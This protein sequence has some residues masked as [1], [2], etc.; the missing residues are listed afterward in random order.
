MQWARI[1]GPGPVAS[2]LASLWA[3]LTG[4][5]GGTPGMPPALTPALQTTPYSG[6]RPTRAKVSQNARTESS[7]ARSSSMAVMCGLPV[8]VRSASAAASPRAGFRQASTT[9]W[10]GSS[11]AMF[12]GEPTPD[13]IAR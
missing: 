8:S 10:P 13:A 3:T 1:P 5:K 9:W 12:A 7:A 4:K 6:G 2:A 11:R